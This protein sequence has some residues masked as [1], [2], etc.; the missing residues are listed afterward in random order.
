MPG[1][2]DPRAP[3]GRFLIRSHTLWFALSGAL[4]AAIGIA[5]L[6]YRLY[7]IDRIISRTL[8]YAVVTTLLA[9]V[10]LASN[11]L[12]QSAVASAT[13][14]GTIAV[15]GSTL[16]VAALF[17][18]IRG[19]VQAPLDRRFDRAHVDAAKV[20]QSFGDRAREE[21]DLVR[22]NDAVVTSAR[23]AVA[24]ASASIWLR[25]VH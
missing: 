9:A 24:P 15:A 7:D 10:F 12:L 20:V 25:P 2:P 11:L 1:A 23:E 19:R 6:R 22:L 17:V 14:E 4:P 13:G 16:L 5:I 18:P 3:H 21:V 8:A